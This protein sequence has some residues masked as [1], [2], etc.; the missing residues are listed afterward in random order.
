MAQG[1]A[2]R[3]DRISIEDDRSLL[4]LAEAYRKFGGRYEL[5]ARVGNDASPDAEAT[6]DDLAAER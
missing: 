2:S 6:F 5:R 1:E 3:Y 4:L